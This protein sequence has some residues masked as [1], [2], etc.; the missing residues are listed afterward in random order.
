[1]PCPDV[2]PSRCLGAIANAC[3]VGSGH[4]KTGGQSLRFIGIT[5]MRNLLSRA[6]AAATA[7]DL[8][9]HGRTT[10]AAAGCGLL[11]RLHGPIL[12]ITGTVLATGSF[13]ATGC[14]V[15][16]G[17]LVATG[18]TRTIF[19]CACLTG[20]CL[21]CAG[22][23]VARCACTRIAGALCAVCR[24]RCGGFGRG[25]RGKGHQHGGGYDQRRSDGQSKRFG[26]QS[27][28][29]GYSSS[30][31]VTVS[32]QQLAGIWHAEAGSCVVGTGQG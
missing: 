2:S 16:T 4:K 23:A 32:P 28:Q 24:H 21:R 10:A 25:G 8:R 20:A 18:S 22:D 11:C 6:D 15:A 5:H 13:L 19:A 17:R 14:F 26:R 7:R 27:G 1:M 30:H 3:A 12:G 9:G 29:H 31:P